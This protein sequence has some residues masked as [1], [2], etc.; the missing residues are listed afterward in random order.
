MK[1]LKKEE[2]KMLNGGVTSCHI[3]GGLAGGGLVLLAAATVVTGGLGLAVAGG[4]S[5]Y[6]SGVSGFHCAVS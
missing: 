2:L 3:S 6:F 4:L 1:T 5:L